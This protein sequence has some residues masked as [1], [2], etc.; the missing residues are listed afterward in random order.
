MLVRGAEGAQVKTRPV[1]E[2]G[3]MPSR[4]SLSSNLGHAAAAEV[5]GGVASA[6][7]FFQ[8]WLENF[9]HCLENFRHRLENFRH[10]L[11]N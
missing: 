3:E 5:R 8:H 9:Q 11:E 2:A 4:R 7:S 6:P 1:F 10:R